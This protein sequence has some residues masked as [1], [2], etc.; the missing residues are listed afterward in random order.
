MP[1][2]RP[3]DLARILQ[4]QPGEERTHR[5]PLAQVQP[6]R[7]V[8]IDVGRLVRLRVVVR[9]Q[10]RDH[11]EAARRHRGHQGGDD[12]GRVVRVR[13]EMQDRDQQ[14]RDRLIE[15]EYRTDPC[16]PDDPAWIPQVAADDRGA[17]DAVQR[18]AGV[19]DHHRVVVDV[20]D[21]ALR[22]L[23]P[24]HLVHVP[25][26]GQPGPDVEELP[27]PRVAGQ[28]ADRAAE[29]TPVLLDG[30]AHHVLAEHVKGPA[31]GLPVSREV[32]LA[33]EH[34]VVHPRDVRFFRAKRHPARRHGQIVSS[35]DNAVI[36][37]RARR[38]NRYRYLGTG[39]RDTLSGRYAN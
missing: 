12:A 14:D 1:L 4:R 39:G 22:R 33:A 13:H 15:A 31:S 17:L 23:R 18:V 26:G 21:A 38:A 32:V 35:P 11:Q 16:V 34:V 3:D 29:E 37:N 30:A 9:R 2:R 5:R 36:G 10:V 20:D 25:H 7:R 24:R 27:D 6:R 28:V 19:R 8:L